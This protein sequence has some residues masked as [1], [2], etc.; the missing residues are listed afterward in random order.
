MRSS[1]GGRVVP[2]SALVQELLR[3]VK[4]RADLDY[5]FD[6]LGS[7]E[8]V[9]PLGEAGLFSNPPPMLVEGQY[10]RFPAWPESAYLARVASLDPQAVVHVVSRIPETDNPR[11]HADLIGA[12]AAAPPDLSRPLL[13]RVEKWLAGPFTSILLD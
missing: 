1:Q 3:G 12:I 5:F 9:E 2:D 8:W 7:P 13:P 6:K 10:R 11:V 4:R